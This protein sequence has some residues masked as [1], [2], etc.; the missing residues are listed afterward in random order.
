MATSNSRSASARDE[1]ERW[2]ADAIAF[3]YARCNEAVGLI[4]AGDTKRAVVILRRLLPQGYRHTFIK[5]R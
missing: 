1:R 5:E 3:C 4:E 2:L